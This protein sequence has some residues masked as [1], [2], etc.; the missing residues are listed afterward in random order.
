MGYEDW[1]I[2]WCQHCF[3]DWK[4]YIGYLGENSCFETRYT[5]VFKGDRAYCQQKAY[6]MRDR[7]N[8]IIILPIRNLV[9]GDMRVLCTVLVIFM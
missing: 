6:R 5:K 4:L 8:E 3:L 1:K 7:G 2:V 9:R